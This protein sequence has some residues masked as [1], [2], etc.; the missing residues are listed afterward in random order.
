VAETAAPVVRSL[1][2]TIW[3]MGV[4]AR[5]IPGFLE[6]VLEE[7]V[8]PGGTVV[9]LMSGTAVV[10]LHCAER[11]RVFA[12]DVQAYAQVIAGSYL[13]H[14][15]ARKERF[16]SSLSFERDLAGAYRKN[17]RALEAL[18]QPALEM[19]EGLLRV[20]ARKNDGAG[21][22]R[23]YRSFLQN[24][25]GMYGGGG[26]T[27]RRS[28]R[29]LYREA[30]A[31]AGEASISRYR[32]DPRRRPACLVTAYYGNVYYGLR[33][34][35]VIDSLRAAIDE[36]DT[37]AAEGERKRV[38]YLSALLHAASISTS[39]TS[40]FAQPRHLTKDSELRA[41]AARRRIDLLASFQ[42]FAREI[43]ERVRATPHRGGNRCFA[44]DYRSFIDERGR[45]RRPC[46]RFP[47]PVDLIYLDP[48]YTQDHYSRFYHVLEV[49][50]RYDYPPLERDAKG[51]VLRGRYPELE[52][53]FLSDFC[54]LGAVEEEF[55]KVIRAAAGS[56][57]KLVLSYAAPSGLLL[58]VY[59]R[60]Y[61]GED[62]VLRLEE[63]CRASYRDVH[64]RRRK[65]LHSGQGESGLAI[66]ELLVVC[67]GPK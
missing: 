23:R 55:R 2:R 53:R 28:G 61:P 56:G 33:Q 11:Y 25:H 39:G 15:P 40:H 35:M 54:R 58:K 5:V 9:D 37:S 3:Y 49:L 66:E 12:N 59:A 63:L 27:T 22:C 50:A 8:P 19:E 42:E 30:A 17:L 6:R 47:A 62:P 52:R 64:T 65:L 29:A 41:M 21:W 45:A 20:E 4:K 43:A 38:H 60:R 57:A 51:R 67:R 46:F 36:L 26:A 34:A 32:S 1:P 13:E 7:E 10:A 18:Y 16:L 14:H 24:P 48:P 31:L 44:R